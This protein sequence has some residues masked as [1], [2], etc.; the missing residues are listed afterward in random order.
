[1][2]PEIDYIPDDEV[3]DEILSSSPDE[4]LE[5]DTPEKAEAAEPEPEKVEEAEEVEID[6]ELKIP[7]PD[8]KEAIS[9]GDMK[10]KV[11]QL[12]RTEAQ[13]IER[14]NAILR[15][16]QVLTEAIQAAG[17]NVPPELKQQ[18]DAQMMQHQERQHELML[19]SMPEMAD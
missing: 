3:L 8:G 15:E 10:D 2:Q 9:L 7:M 4:P 16:Q 6:Y 1:M 18:M 11:T 5:T 17:G 13:Y 14:E 19:Q 12:E